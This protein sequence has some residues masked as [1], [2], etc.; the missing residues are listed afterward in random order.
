MITAR[1]RTFQEYILHRDSNAHIY[2]RIRQIEDD[3]EARHEGDF[4][5]KGFSYPAQAEVD[6]LVDRLYSDNVHINWRERVVCPITQLNNRLRAMVHFMQ[7][8]LNPRKDSNIY[9]A[10]QLTPLYA[11]LV[12]KFTNL[13]GSEYLG[14]D[15][16]P[17]S[18]N[19]KG[20]RHEDAT[21]LSF[22]DGELD[23]YL[24][25]ECFEHIPDFKKAFTESYR[26]LKEGG[27][28]YWTVPFACSNYPN[29]I[30]A[31]VDE[32]GTINHILEPEYHGD[33]VHP[34]SG[35]L[36]FTHFGWQM[37]DQLR[38]IGYKDAYAITYWCDTLGYYGDGQFLFCAI[39]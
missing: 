4:T 22:K 5:V 12:N 30:R 7:F 16:P 17:S 19:E 20:L 27:M 3:L 32:N 23:Y 11:Y 6:F 34:D 24:S 10:E 9:I 18:I 31:T 2:E 28:M 37:F 29:V 26:I 8:E 35:I 39:K 21:N 14:P 1:L 36:A 38:E 13:T 15:V 25:F 33:P